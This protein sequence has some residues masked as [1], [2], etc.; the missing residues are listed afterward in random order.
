MLELLLSRVEF[1]TSAKRIEIINLETSIKLEINTLGVSPVQIAASFFPRRAMSLEEGSEFCSLSI[2]EFLGL[3][4]NITL[5]LS[6]SLTS[7]VAIVIVQSQ[8]IIIGPSIHLDWENGGLV[9]EGLIAH[10]V[11]PWCKVEVFNWRD[12]VGFLVIFQH[13]VVF[14][15]WVD[16]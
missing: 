7:I 11:D 10:F 3:R 5:N 1:D 4:V 13:V 14:T 9:W 2:N 12:G 8:E 15:G 16:T 6:L